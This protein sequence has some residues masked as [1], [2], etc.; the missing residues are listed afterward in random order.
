[1]RKQK[2][3]IKMGRQR[4]VGNGKDNENIKITREVSK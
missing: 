1:M 3:E 2:Q 4:A